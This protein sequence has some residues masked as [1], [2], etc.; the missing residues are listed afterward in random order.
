MPHLDDPLPSGDLNP[1]LLP[2]PASL[3]HAAEPRREFRRVDRPTAV[4]VHLR[5][6]MEHQTRVISDR[7]RQGT[8]VVWAAVS[9]RGTREWRLIGRGFGAGCGFAIM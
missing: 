1:G 4:G 6:A 3:L 7:N 9:I 2:L 5:T 8:A